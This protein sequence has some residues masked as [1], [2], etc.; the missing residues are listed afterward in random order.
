MGGV[1]TPSDGVVAVARGQHVAVVPSVARRG[2]G[3]AVVRVRHR[4]V[5]S[6]VPW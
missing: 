1:V 2:E 5:L 3:V 4:S 6:C